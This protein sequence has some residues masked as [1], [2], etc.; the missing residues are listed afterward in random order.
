M[1]LK[2]RMVLKI[3]LGTVPRLRSLRM[4]LLLDIF[5]LVGKVLS[6]CSDNIPVVIN[7]NWGKGNVFYL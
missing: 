3:S 2:T 1:W 7:L 6:A 5:L 4:I